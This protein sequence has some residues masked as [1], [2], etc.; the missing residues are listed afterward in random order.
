MDYRIGFNNMSSR[1]LVPN[2]DLFKNSI[3]LNASSKVHE[4]LTISTNININRS[5]SN[6]RPSSNRGTNPLQ[7]AYAVKP[8][9]DI[10]E[11]KNYWEPGKEGFQQRAPAEDINNPYFLAYEVNNSFVRD[12]IFGNVKADWQ[13]TKDFSLMGRYALDYYTEQR[14]SKIAPSYTGEPNN[15]AYGIVNLKNYERNAD[16]LATYKKGIGAF[17]LS[18]SAGGNALLRNGFNVRNASLP[19]AGLIVPG[20]YSINNIKSGALD[21][22]SSRYEKIIY[23]AYALANLGWKD[24]VYLDVTARNDWSSTLPPEN[25]SYFYP[26]ASLSLLVN[27]MLHLGNKVN[28]IKL[29]GGWPGRQ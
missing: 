8:G 19:S 2:S 7:W 18:L 28:L 5:W 10:N 27:E 25:R 22:S 9:L 20:V 23:S 13:I 6:N 12:R 14:E 4:K 21:Y 17:N 15:G 1:G 26:S 24:M 29:R 3:T 11:Y 16:F